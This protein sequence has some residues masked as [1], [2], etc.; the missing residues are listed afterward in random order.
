MF[1]C[2]LG[3]H[4]RRENLLLPWVGVFWE[5]LY[6]GLTGG[7]QHCLVGRPAFRLIRLP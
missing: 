4:R 1:I 7:F 3:F 5:R 6:D 2:A